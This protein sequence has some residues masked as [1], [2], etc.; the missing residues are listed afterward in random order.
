[1]STKPPKKVRKHQINL[2]HHWK[3]KFYFEQL[4]IKVLT[5]SVLSILLLPGSN[6]E[7]CDA[8]VYFEFLDEIF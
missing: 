5:P 3:R 1:M 2:W 4:I 6:L 8:V 7:T